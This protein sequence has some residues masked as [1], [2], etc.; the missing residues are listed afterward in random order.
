M[1]TRQERQQQRT[2]TA[3]EGNTGSRLCRHGSETGQEGEGEGQ[4]RHGFSQCARGHRVEGA[5]VV[6]AHVCLG[7][8]V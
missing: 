8:G 1:S 5:R 2:A 4:R 6:G 7:F 3:C